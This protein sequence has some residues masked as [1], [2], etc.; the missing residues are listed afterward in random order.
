MW[1]VERNLCASFA[2]RS[3]IEILGSPLCM[4]C[5]RK[6]YW[7]VLRASFAVQSL[8]GKCFVPAM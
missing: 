2:V 6:S 8:S 4:L 5:S 1:S 7:E 3:N